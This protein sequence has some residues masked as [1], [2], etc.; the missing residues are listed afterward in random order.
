MNIK[1]S[2]LREYLRASLW[3]VPVLMSAVAIGAA[4]LMLHLDRVLDTEDN[5]ASN[6]WFYAGGSENAREILSTIA[7]SMIQVA[8]VVFS[9]TV[10][11]LSLSSSQFGPRLLRTFMKDW[12]T[13]LIIGSFVATYI[14]CLV[15]LRNVLTQ[16]DEDFIP[17]L[18]IAFSIVLTLINIILLIYFIHHVATSIQADTLIHRVDQ[19]LGGNMKRLFPE[20]LGEGDE[21]RDGP[22]EFE[23]AA[24]PNRIILTF[25]EHGY[26]QS[27]DND[28]LWDLAVEEDLLLEINNRPGQYVVEGGVMLVVHA[29]KQI[30]DKVP[31]RLRD[32]FILGHQRTAEQDVEFSI[33]QLVE[34]ALRAL[35]PSLND[36]FTAMSCIDRLTS[37][38]IG[39]I[40]RRFPSPYRYDEKG[41][42]R[43]LAREQLSFPLIFSAAFDRIRLSALKNPAVLIRLLKAMNMILPYCR[44]P[45]QLRSVQDQIEM[46]MHA[47]EQSVEEQHDLALMRAAVPNYRDRSGQGSIPVP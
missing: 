17:N 20:K 15:V 28:A 47:G 11:V 19:E 18:S 10:V 27:L 4:F 36:P 37:A 25:K 5:F 34:V 45:E 41:F 31:G 7:S 16:D 13:Q 23:N 40:E 44:T 1:L 43:V 33:D 29:R 26:V 21:D 38:M 14:Y 9:I 8:G 35:S 3:F 30:P 46:L 22:T 39:F 6:L 32:G 12:S 24:Y 2:N 42:L